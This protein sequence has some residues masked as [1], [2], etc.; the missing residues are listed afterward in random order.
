MTESDLNTLKLISWTADEDQI[1]TIAKN[2]EIQKSVE[3]KSGIGVQLEKSIM[4][5]QFS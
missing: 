3:E 4:D 2:L 5:G 1:D